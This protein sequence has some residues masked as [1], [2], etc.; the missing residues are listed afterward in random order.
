MA[1][2]DDEKSKAATEDNET[3]TRED[4]PVWSVSAVISG[5]WKMKVVRLSSDRLVI[6]LT[7]F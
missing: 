3:T 4:L 6:V 1:I 7:L 2:E 5:I